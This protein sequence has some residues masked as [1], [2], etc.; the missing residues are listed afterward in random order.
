MADFVVPDGFATITAAIVAAEAAGPVAVQ[1]VRV[2][3]GTFTENLFLAATA[4]TA[5][6]YLS[7][8]S[9]SGSKDVTV[10][11]SGGATTLDCNNRTNLQVKNIHLK[12][13]T[14][15]QLRR[16]GVGSFIQNV[17]TSGGS[18]GFEN[19]NNNLIRLIDCEFHNHINGASLSNADGLL[20]ERCSFHDNTSNGVSG[21][22]NGSV[23]F[24]ACLFY[25]NGAHGFSN[26][27]TV[28]IGL[29][30]FIQCNFFGNTNSGINFQNPGGKRLRILNCIFR[31]QGDYAIETDEVIAASTQ[32]PLI[33]IDGNDY[34]GN[35]NGIFFDGTTATV[36]LAAMKTLTGQDANSIDTDPKFT[37]ETGG[38][39]DFHLLAGSPCINFGVGAGVK[40]DVFKKDYPDVH[41]PAIGADATL[42]LVLPER[43]LVVPGTSPWV[44]LFDLIT[45]I[46]KADPELATFAPAGEWV[47]RIFSGI[48][49]RRQPPRNLSALPYIEFEMA[50]GRNRGR[51][52]ESADEMV[53]VHFMFTVGSDDDSYQNMYKLARDTGAAL[54]SGLATPDEFFTWQVGQED[55]A[56]RFWRLSA[57]AEVPLDTTR[58][59]LT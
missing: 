33:R 53:R 55:K 46:L 50:S 32:F 45:A 5:V 2:K 21:S 18:T 29:F 24:F 57:T 31:S 15:R 58:L 16:P 30:E 37:N 3:S 8:E 39:E 14:S 12:D 56:G 7:I 11:G 27:N 36:T 41:H 38:S 34:S 40:A 49:E 19:V 51:T 47:D 10:D 28:R 26:I 42:D 25:S 22:T 9:F 52:D 20:F 59:T 54:R 6:N 44:A 48:D 13:G 35:T 23:Q 1:R 17:E 43:G 4:W